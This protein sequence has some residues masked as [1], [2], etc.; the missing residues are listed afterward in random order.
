MALRRTAL[1]AAGGLAAVATGSW[2][3]LSG[4][5]PAEWIRVE[6]GDLVLSVEVSGTLRALE[7]DLLGPPSVRNQWQFKI[8]R[9]ASEGEVVTKGTPVLS[10]D[11]SDLERQLLDRRA[12][13]ESARKEIEKKEADLTSRRDQEALRLAEAE[14]KERKA[15]LKLARPSDVVS[16]REMDKVRE[17]LS[18]ARKEIDFLKKRIAALEDAG[19]AEL[20]LLTSQRDRALGRI[21]ELGSAIERMTVKAPRE[22]TV[23]HHSRRGGDKRKVGD[24]VSLDDPVIEIPNLERMMAQG[25]VDEVDAGLVSTGQSVRLRLDAYP[26]IELHGRVGST[27]NTVQKPNPRSPLKMLR[28]D[29]LLDR[30]DSRKM[31]PGMRFRGRIEIERVEGAL[32]LPGEAVFSTPEGPVAYRRGLASWVRPVAVKLVLGRR[33]ARRV[34]VREGLTADDFV[35][36]RA[37]R[38]TREP[39]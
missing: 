22:G 4:D 5:A 26:E 3:L 7:S 38:A 29:V 20:S 19:R 36:I 1:I 39:S 28:V 9:M 13:Y 23:I 11:V 2:W 18:L 30:T 15:E 34:E 21:E 35:V 16:A 12:E 17:E 14:G 27:G 31:R 8:A 33:D 25:E 6:R 10:F 37:P 24:T 32:L